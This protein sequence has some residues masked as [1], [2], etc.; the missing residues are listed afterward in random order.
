MGCG[1]LGLPL[2]VSL[3]KDGYTVHG[4]TTSEEKTSLLQNLGITPFLIS[5]SE[6]KVNG[7]IQGFLQGVNVLII[8]IPPKL[9]G[10]GRE[11]YVKKI[12]LLHNEMT[13][14]SVEDV[15]F[16]SSTSVYGDLDGDVTEENEPKPITESGKQLLQAENIVQ[17]S[18]MYN[19]LIIKQIPQVKER[20]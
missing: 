11:N 6:T 19:L 1:W 18:L 8:N 16:V 2:A 12:Q 10:G 7:D 13:Q 4:S 17:P 9:R 15:I 3:V 5:L 14:S 20:K